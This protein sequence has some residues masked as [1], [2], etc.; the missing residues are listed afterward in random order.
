MPPEPADMRADDGAI[1]R[2]DRNSSSALC[3]LL[4]EDICCAA[5]FKVE[6]SFVSAS[7]WLL[8]WTAL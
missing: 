1:D 7:H 6:N 8:T 2:A 3:A 4:W 5:S